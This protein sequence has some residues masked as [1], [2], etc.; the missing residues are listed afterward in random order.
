MVL[1]FPHSVI[2]MT[3]PFI[4]IH[5]PPLSFTLLRTH[6]LDFSIINWSCD[7]IVERVVQSLMLEEDSEGKVG[8][9][10]KIF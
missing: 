8:V 2:L 9:P 1:V 7:L 6:T 4:G 3:R 5:N 10:R